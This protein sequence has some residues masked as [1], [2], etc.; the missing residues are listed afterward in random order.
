[1]SGS[2]IY[3]ED[4]DMEAHYLED[5]DREAHFSEATDKEADATAHG[6]QRAC[7]A[8]HAF[9]Q[10]KR[11]YAAVCAVPYFALYFKCVM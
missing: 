7:H 9:S 10:V 3:L 5:L 1:M 6:H 11:G 8:S 2:I 4:L